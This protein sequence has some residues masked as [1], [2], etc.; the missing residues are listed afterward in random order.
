MTIP[1]HALEAALYTRLTGG[2]AF[3]ALLSGTASVYNTVAPAGASY[4]FCVFNLASGIDLN[5]EPGHRRHQLDYQIKVVSQTSQ[6]NAGLASVQLDAL[7]HA[8]GPSAAS[9]LSV[10]GYRNLFQERIHPVRFVEPSD[11]ATPY[12]HSG[13]VY[14][15]H[16]EEGTS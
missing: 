8:A 3:T 13:G 15:F 12:Y 1:E 2:T 10:T 9:R 6:A 11:V 4:P 5:A 14:R 7:M 16:L